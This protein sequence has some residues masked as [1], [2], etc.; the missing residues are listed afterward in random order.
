MATGR[1]SPREIQRPSSR[2]RCVPL[3]GSGHQTRI[4]S[5]QQLKHCCQRP[6]TNLAPA[7]SGTLLGALM[8]RLL[9]GGGHSQI[10]ICAK[11]RRVQ[12]DKA[13]GF[14]REL[15][16]VK[17]AGLRDC[18]SCAGRRAAARSRPRVHSHTEPGVSSPPCSP[19]EGTGGPPPPAAMV[20]LPLAGGT[21]PDP[22]RSAW[23]PTPAGDRPHP[24]SR[25][26]PSQL[27]GYL[28]K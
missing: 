28:V 3:V 9:Q 2:S 6:A 12:G 21:P 5:E 25:I 7:A 18:R 4:S 1:S 17:A 16:R 24:S 11:V 14:W 10:E 8:R 19:W 20:T 22:L 26:D 15:E 27:P 13:Y 23:R